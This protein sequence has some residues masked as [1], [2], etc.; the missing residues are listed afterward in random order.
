MTFQH[1]RQLLLRIVRVEVGQETKIATVNTNNLN[2]IASQ[3]S[4][5]A[6]HIAVAADHHGEIRL[7]ANFRQRAGSDAFKL[8]LLGDLLLD[9]HFI[10]FTTQPAI[11]HFM[12]RQCGRVTRMADDPNTPEMIIHFLEVLV[13]DE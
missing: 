7:L 13:P 2:I 8:Q 10:A 3:R 4:R 12:C 1:V 9:H 5:R 6:Q 11:Q